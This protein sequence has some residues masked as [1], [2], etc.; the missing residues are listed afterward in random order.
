M[1][2]QLDFGIHDHENIDESYEFLTNA[3]PS[4][5]TSCSVNDSLE[6]KFTGVKHL[7][8]TGTCLMPRWIIVFIHISTTSFLDRNE[9]LSQLLL[10][11]CQL[12]LQQR[13]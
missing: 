7:P 6:L 2:T 9:L 4:P 5:A 12:K 13:P 10:K 11:H 3:F 1:R 8:G